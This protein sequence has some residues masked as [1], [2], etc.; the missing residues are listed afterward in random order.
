[1]RASLELNAGLG[2]WSHYPVEQ[3]EEVS[4]QTQENT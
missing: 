2:E 3:M 1:M 4:V